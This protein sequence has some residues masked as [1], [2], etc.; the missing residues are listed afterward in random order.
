MIFMKAISKASTRFNADFVGF[1]LHSKQHRS[2]SNHQL[3]L[4]GHQKSRVQ[5]S[6]AFLF[7]PT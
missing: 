6:T 1:F 5:G 2:V 3:F 4:K 7:T